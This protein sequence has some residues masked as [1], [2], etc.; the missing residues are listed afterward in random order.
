MPTGTP[1]SRHCLV[2]LQDGRFVI[3]WENT[4]FQD[5][6]TGEFLHCSEH[7][8]DHLMQ[9]DELELLKRISIITE[10]DPKHAYVLPLPEQNRRTLD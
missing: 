1:I 4:L 8:V 7:E 3:D 5:I 6:R 2:V 9:D 10:F